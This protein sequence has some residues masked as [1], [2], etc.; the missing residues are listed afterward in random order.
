[1]RAD[2]DIEQA[3]QVADVSFRYDPVMDGKKVTGWDFVPVPNRPVA[4][5][6]PAKRRL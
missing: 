1:M 5:T 3:K 2:P 6:L 4:Q